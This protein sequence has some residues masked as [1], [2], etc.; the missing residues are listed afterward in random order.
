MSNTDMLLKR[1]HTL[2]KKTNQQQ[3]EREAG[4]LYQQWQHADELIHEGL[5]RK[6]ALLSE[7]QTSES[8]REQ[9]QQIDRELE[10]ERTPAEHALL[11]RYRRAFPC[12]GA[13]KRLQ[14][15]LEC[16][17]ESEAA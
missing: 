10:Q 6:L 16:Y 12:T 2:L 8:I 17:Q 4:P 15:Q 5:M 3:N 1:A 7:G 14:L 13:R 9:C 11:A